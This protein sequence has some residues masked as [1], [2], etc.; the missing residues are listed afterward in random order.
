MSNLKRLFINDEFQ[1]LKGL[2]IIE[3]SV[4]PWRPQELVLRGENKKRRMVID[5]WETV[6]LYTDVDA[7]PIPEV[8][9]M[10]ILAA[11]YKFFS[12]IQLPCDY[13]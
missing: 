11:A 12:T 10:L 1:Q 8:E 6:N 5:Y 13:H 3:V 4:S 2:G 7:Y 9:F